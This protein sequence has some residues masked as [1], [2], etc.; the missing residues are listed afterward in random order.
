MKITVTET[1]FK[2][3]FVKMNRADNFSSAGLSAL[4]EYCEELERDLGEE[5]ELDIIALCCD[6]SEAFFDEIADDYRID[7]SEFEGVE[8]FAAVVEYL[9]DNTSI[10]YADQETGMILYQDF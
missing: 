6:F 5:Y 2:D 3:Q 1:M 9:E 7:L 10:V 8:Q 4:F